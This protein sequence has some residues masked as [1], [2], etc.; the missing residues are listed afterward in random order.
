MDIFIFIDFAVVSIVCGFFGYW[1]LE[2]AVTYGPG[3]KKKRVVLMIIATCF[4][5]ASVWVGLVFVF[6]VLLAMP[7]L[8]LLVFIALVP[9]G[10]ITWAAIFYAKKE[11]R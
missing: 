11:A 4:F 9:T 5:F 10:A 2:K 1:I 6:N 8:K 7:S 3:D